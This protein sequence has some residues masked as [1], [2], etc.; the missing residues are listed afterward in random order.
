MS[1]ETPFAAGFMDEYFAE[2]DEHLATIRRL[3]L[4]LEASAAADRP[5]RAPVL[6]ELFQNFPNELQ[7]SDPSSF[8]GRATDL[9]VED[10]LATPEQQRPESIE[11][12]SRTP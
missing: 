9:E 5:V 7:G 8:D 3:L 12:E 6:E 2:C 4:D 11:N 10:W 1:D